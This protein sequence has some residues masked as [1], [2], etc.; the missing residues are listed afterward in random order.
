MLVLKGNHILN[1]VEFSTD[2]QIILITMGVEFGKRAKTVLC[3]AMINEPTV[4]DVSRT[5]QD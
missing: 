4:T 5:M 2:P 3:A 1:L